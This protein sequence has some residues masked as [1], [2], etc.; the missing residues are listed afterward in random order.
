MGRLSVYELA[1]KANEL[2]VTGATG[3]DTDEE[4]SAWVD[5]MRDWADASVDKFVALRYAIE[6]A[7]EEEK[8]MR[9][10]AAKF[11]SRARRFAAAGDRIKGLCKELVAAHAE[12]TGN[13]KIETFDG[14]YVSVITLVGES[15]EVVDIDAVPAEYK[16][17]TVA[18]DKVAIKAAHKDG[19]TIPG[20]SITP[21]ST[22]SL[23][24]GK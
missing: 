7:G 23:R 3:F 13:T 2:V 4:L 10:L 14:S 24:F 1:V 5:Q 9:E 11:E 15:V 18:P 12:V 17:V 22:A 19:Q 20:V 21:T 8:A 16:R 6:K